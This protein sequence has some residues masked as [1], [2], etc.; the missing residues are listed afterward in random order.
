MFK[1]KIVFI[2]GGA[3][4]IGRGIVEAFRQAGAVVA[5]C[6]LNKKQAE[7]TARETGA[8]F[9][10]ADVSD[11][12]ALTGVLDAVCERFGDIDIVINNAGIGGFSPL[13]ETSVEHFDRILAVNLRPVFITG[14]YMAARRNTPEGRARYGRILNIASTRWLQSE[15]GSEGYAASKGGIVSLTHALAISLSEYN[16]TV[17]CISPGWIDNGSFGA[18]SDRDRR[19]HP[20]GRVGVPADIAR[21]CLFLADPANDFI[22]GQ[23]IVVDGGMTKRMIYEE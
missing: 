6:D 16:I 8:V 9:Y 10:L 13:A 2:T 4:G 18:I 23:N 21:A 7:Q 20:S 14:Q 15:P 11:A 1:D 22:D 3:H 5:F 19:Q 12:A 17:N